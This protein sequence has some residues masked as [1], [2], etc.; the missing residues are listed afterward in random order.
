MMNVS[1]LMG[2]FHGPLTLMLHAVQFL[3]CFYLWSEENLKCFVLSMS[4]VHFL[5]VCL[6]FGLSVVFVV[7]VVIIFFFPVVFSPR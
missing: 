2:P 4:C 6:F 1:R 3:Y 7:N 5:F